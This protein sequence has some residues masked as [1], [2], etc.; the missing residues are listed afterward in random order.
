MRG[1][2]DW[3]AIGIRDDEHQFCFCGLNNSSEEAMA[4]LNKYLDPTYTVGH[5]HGYE[6]I[7]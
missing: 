1:E 3:F 6:P 7:K 2:R 4:Q 5:V